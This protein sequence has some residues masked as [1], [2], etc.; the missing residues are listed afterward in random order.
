MWELVPQGREVA[1]ASSGKTHGEANKTKRKQRVKYTRPT[2]YLLPEHTTDGRTGPQTYF[3]SSVR[4]MP[5]SRPDRAL[6]TQKKTPPFMTRQTKVHPESQCRSTKI[7][8]RTNGD[9]LQRR[10]GAWGAAAKWK[11]NI[12]HG[13]GQ[14]V[15]LTAARKY[16][17]RTC[18]RHDRNRR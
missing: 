18:T 14:R 5:P 2:H 8:A 11:A 12:A 16:N 15:H 17:T 9:T 10:R 4:R 13:G 6:K 7:K 1:P 3:F